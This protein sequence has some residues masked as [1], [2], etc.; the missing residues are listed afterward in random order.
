MQNIPMAY[1]ALELP[2]G[3]VLIAFRRGLREVDRAGTTVREWQTAP[4][5]RICAY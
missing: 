3:N 4:I 2:G 5:R 1:D